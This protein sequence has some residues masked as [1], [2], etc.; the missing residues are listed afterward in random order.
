MAGSMTI[1][2]VLIS[3][4]R[5]MITSGAELMIPLAQLAC[6]YYPL[7]PII[8]HS[9]AVFCFCNISQV[10]NYFHTGTDMMVQLKRPLL[11]P[12]WFKGCAPHTVSVCCPS[13]KLVFLMTYVK[14]L[15]TCSL[16]DYHT[17]QER[18][19]NC[20]INP[21]VNQP[22]TLRKHWDPFRPYSEVYLTCHHLAAVW[23]HCS[24][25]FIY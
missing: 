6:Y 20:C 11:R 13:A 4:L 9:F 8:H 12:C 15:V 1:F 21:D 23:T 3:I 24:N 2:M 16:T 14:I 10:H 22:N 25:W 17:V 18:V 7:F 19:H 5:D